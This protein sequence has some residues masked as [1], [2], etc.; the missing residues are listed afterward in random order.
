M[1]PT[2]ATTWRNNRPRRRRIARVLLLEHLAIAV[3][4]QQGGSQ[5]VG[6]DGRKV[7]QFAVAAGEF[8]GAGGHGLF[9]VQGIA[10]DPVQ[11]RPVY[12]PQQ[13]RAIA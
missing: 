10:I 13:L 6:H 2:P 5:V 3:N 8:F 12:V 11:A 7:L 1:R 9:E 4:G